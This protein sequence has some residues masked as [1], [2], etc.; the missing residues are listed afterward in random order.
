MVILSN[1]QFQELVNAVQT[2]QS[3]IAEAKLLPPHAGYSLVIHI[4]NNNKR[5]RVHVYARSFGFAEVVK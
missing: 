1:Y 2:A 4:A 3:I 5:T